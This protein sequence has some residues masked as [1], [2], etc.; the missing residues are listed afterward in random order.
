MP[1]YKPRPFYP[2]TAEEFTYTRLTSRMKQQDVADLLHVSL[3]TVKNWE[4][5][6]ATIPY[7]AFKLIRI[8]GLHELPGDRWAGWV[9]SQGA[10]WSPAGRR[11]ES[12]E[13]PYIGNMFAMARFWL[14][15]RKARQAR[16]RPVIQLI[17]SNKQVANG[18]W[19]ANPMQTDDM[20]HHRGVFSR[21]SISTPK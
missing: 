10:L 16:P 20:A 3:R 18:V 13:L 9:I 7:A 8:A 15:E 6:K 19:G 2:P 21:S 17:S 12:H 11:F 5:G 14:A 4:S 1:A